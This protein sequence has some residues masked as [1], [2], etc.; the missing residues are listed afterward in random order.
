MGRRIE[1]IRRGFGK[2]VRANVGI[3]QDEDSLGYGRMCEEDESRSS[4]FC[5][6][7][8]SL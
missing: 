4:A 2:G 6:R 7:I 5:P 8:K 3:P 1:R